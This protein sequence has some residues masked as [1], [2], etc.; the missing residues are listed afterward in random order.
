[1][2]P[3]INEG[4]SW[5]VVGRDV[6]LLVNEKGL[7]NRGLLLLLLLLLEEEEE[8]LLP[9]VSKLGLQRNASSSNFPH[10][11]CHLSPVPGGLNPKKVGELQYGSVRH[12][13]QS[14]YWRT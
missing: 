10:A 12:S 9:L 1:M 14:L 4:V 5:R 11:S 2:D 3:E 7:L 6:G 13:Y 8:L